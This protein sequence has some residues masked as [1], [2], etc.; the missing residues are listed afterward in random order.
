MNFTEILK[1]YKWY[2]LNGLILIAAFIFI[3]MMNLH[4]DYTSDDFIYHFVYDTPGNPYDGTK[5]ISSPIDVIVSMINH[6]K[7][8]NARIV[9][10][11]L[12]QAVLPFGKLFFRIFNSFVYV[13]LGFLIYKHA[14]YGKGEKPALLVLIYAAMW[15]FLP[16]FGLTVLWASGAA[17]YLWCATLILLFLLPYRIY[18]QKGQTKDSILKAVLMGIF[19]ILAGC[20]NE[21]TGGGAVLMACLFIIICFIKKSKIPKWMWAG[22]VGGALG[23]VLLLTAP[24]N[25]RFSTELTWELLQGRMKEVFAISKELTTV[26]FIVGGFIAVVVIMQ[27]FYKSHLTADMFMPLAY[28]LS[29]TAMMAVLVMSPMYP[30]RAWFTPVVFLIISV[31]WLASEIDFTDVRPMLRVGL[32][33]AAAA[34]AI[35]VFLSSFRTEYSALSATYAQVKEGL[36]LIEQAQENGD[37]AVTIPIPVPSQSEYDPYNK[38]SYLGEGADLWVNAWMEQYYGIESIMGKKQ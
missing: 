15:F 1:K 7:L 4:T 36:E 26:L 10:H 13:A 3:L 32:K 19:G 20:T 16:Q 17:N 9:A 8:C 33:T 12:L 2:I 22:T 38:A 21:N 29:S 37:S 27:K 28:A 23:V 30:E 25:Y 31:A 14:A 18:L 11:G 24:I 34:I 5:A 35:V 6:R